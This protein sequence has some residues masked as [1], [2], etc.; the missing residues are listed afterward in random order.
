MRSTRLSSGN[1]LL[2][3]ILL[4]LFLA[5]A[6]GE[7]I[8]DRMI[9]NRL[10]KQARLQTAVMDQSINAIVANLIVNPEKT[11]E[12]RCRLKDPKSGRIYERTVNY[13]YVPELKFFIGFVSDFEKP[14]ESVKLLLNVRMLIMAG[15]L[16]SAFLVIV[17]IVNPMARER[18]RALK[19]PDQGFKNLVENSP[20]NIIRY[21]T[22]CRCIYVNPR[23]EKT[24][25]ASLQ[26]FY[27]KTPMECFP[28]GP[29][30][31]LQDRV[32]EVLKTGKNVE[33]EVVAPDTGD[34]EQ[35]HSI[36]LTAE[37]N[38]DGMIV[39]VL[40]VG[41]DITDRKLSEIALKESRRKLT[42]LSM[43]DG[44][45]GICNRRRFDEVLRQECA[46]HA[47]S[48]SMLSLIMLDIDHFKSYN[49]SLGHLSG[50]NCL[51]RV[52]EV[53][54]LCASRAPDFTARYGGEEFACIL[55]ETDSAGAVRI[56]EKIH[57]ELSALAI[58]HP[59]SPTADTVTVS[60]GLAAIRCTE[61]TR[62]EDII[63]QADK[64]LYKAKTLG[65]NRFEFE[66]SD[67]A[68]IP[69]FMGAKDTLLHLVWK[70]HFCSGNSKID[71][72]H[73]AL[74]RASNSLLKAIFSKRPKNELAE[75]VAMLLKDIKLHF[76]DEEAILNAVGF[77]GLKQHAEKHAQL[78]DEGQKQ[79][80]AL[81]EN[82]NSLSAGSEIFSFLVYK[83]IY[84]H[85]LIA[86]REFFLFTKTNSESLH[87]GF[88]NNQLS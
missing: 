23:L 46:R 66:V 55:P 19:D 40:G 57:R 9:R 29:F 83:V 27:G 88:K 84:E 53:I 30:R 48:G 58:L 6:A 4:C 44:L 54:V 28:E 50:D 65:R 61:Q 78:Y 3:G 45:T 86:D 82:S 35:Y 33:I 79:F 60:I 71:T 31:E 38:S 2:I 51:K 68:D 56:A 80:R 17:F 20:D 76:H 14:M 10:K 69:D 81:K 39:G 5:S 63:G 75:K 7:L 24:L 22:K 77:P 70:D 11:G 62:P 73:Q 74:F 21:D 12:F 85:M 87:G 16:L 1:K 34:G 37:R 42:S 43:T 32:A 49:D 13:R 41:R 52:A 47:R 59:S 25:G 8:A 26:S 72:Q 15:F 67:K 36:H 18:A 64:M